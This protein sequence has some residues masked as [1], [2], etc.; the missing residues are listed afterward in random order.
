M[1][2]SRLLANR[3]WGF[4]MIE[5]SAF[6]VLIVLALAVYL[7]KVGGGKDSAQIASIERQI[8]S[9]K[10]QIRLL[11]AAVAKSEQPARIERLSTSYLKLAP[12]TDKHEIEPAALVDVARGAKALPTP[13]PERPPAP[14][15]E[16]A[17]KGAPR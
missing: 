13:P 9:E 2:L 16:P 4:R 10:Q 5:V 8:K 1:K 17:A 3:V 14:A 7:A 6:T 12:A 11:E 15:P